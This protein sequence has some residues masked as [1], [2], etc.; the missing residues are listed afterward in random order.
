[1]YMLKYI[2]KRLGLMIMTFTIIFV[3][4]FVLIKLLP[5]DTNTV[6]IG[7]DSELLKIRLRERGYFEPI[8]KQL[9]LYVKRIVTKGDF[10]IGINMPQYRFRNV[11]EVFVEKL[12]PTILINIYSSLLSAISVRINKNCR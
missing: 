11:W 2:L 12:P 5:I 6:G 1:M 4:C 3:M 8:P 7:Q 10:G 9:F